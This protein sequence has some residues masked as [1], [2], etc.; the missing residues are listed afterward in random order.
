MG[1]R[2]RVL[3]IQPPTSFNQTSPCLDDKQFGLGL[4][5]NA[6]WLEAH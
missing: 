3:F 5:A 2:D 1:Q 6:A 4:L